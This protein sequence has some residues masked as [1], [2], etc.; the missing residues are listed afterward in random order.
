LSARGLFDR[1][2]VLWASF[3]LE[4]PA[5]KIYAVGDSG[6]GDGT[7]FRRVRELH[8]P[9]RVA[10]LPIGAYEPRWF[11]R[12]QHMNPEDAVKALADCGAELA[13]AHH[14]GTFQLTDE[15]IDA[16]LK[17]LHDAR[18]A[19]NVRRDK[20]IALHPGQIFEI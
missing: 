2:K 3:V 5:G 1:N 15:E 19:A 16:P 10:L 6:Y 18:E 20:F 14:H 8:G 9:L 11:M 12:D 13:L 17:E 4:T 7:H